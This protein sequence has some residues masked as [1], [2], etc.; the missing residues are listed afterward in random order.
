V[1]SRTHARAIR[2]ASEESQL[3]A[4][5]DID[6]EKAEKVA[7]EFGVEVANDLDALLARDDIDAIAVCVP[8]GLHAQVALAAMAAGKHVVV[9]KPADISLAEIDKMIAARDA[10]GVQVMSI[11]QHRFDEASQ[12]VH[13]AVTDGKFGVITS[14]S[15][16]INW[17][18]SQGYYDSGDWRGTWELDGG[19]ALMNQGV[20]TVDLLV[21][22][23]GKPVE[24][25]AY[26]TRRAHERIEVEDI[27]VATVKFESGAVAT[28][29]GTTAAYPGLTI[30]VH[31][32]GAKG[33]AVIDND[34]LS[35]FHVDDGTTKESAYGASGAGNQAEQ[36]VGPDART[37]DHAEQYRDF[38]N[39]LRTGDKPLVTLEEA[40]RS[41]GVVLGVYES[42]RTGAPVALESA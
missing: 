32:H 14:G 20:H 21:W 35:Y 27:A 10:A 34:R 24:V 33:S 25:F 5:T 41:V 22:M 26:A 9:E 37:N 28:I 12:I 18:R 31:V 17:W 23:L 11:S 7:A 40:R 38:L 3:V 6:R 39:A 16:A 13:R 4:V 42:A 29:L 15:A 8:S 19:G 30:R 36:L 2:D 1:I